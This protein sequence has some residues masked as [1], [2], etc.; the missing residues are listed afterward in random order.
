MKRPPKT[1]Y[2]NALTISL[3]NRSRDY[4]VLSVHGAPKKVYQT[5]ATTSVNTT[6]IRF[7]HDKTMV[8][9]K[10]IAKEKVKIR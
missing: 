2:W 5:H 9:Q 6:K 3:D 4:P 1:L 8:N 10:G 7:Y